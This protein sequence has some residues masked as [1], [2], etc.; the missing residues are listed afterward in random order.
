MNS[1]FLLHHNFI[2]HHTNFEN[3]TVPDSARSVVDQESACTVL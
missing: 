1:I 2:G 3:K